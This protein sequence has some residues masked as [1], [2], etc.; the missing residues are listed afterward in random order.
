MEA[1]QSTRVME[2]S[3]DSDQKNLSPLCFRICNLSAVAFYTLQFFYC[4]YIFKHLVTKNERS[5]S[6]IASVIMMIY[7]SISLAIFFGL[8]DSDFYNQEKWSWHQK[9]Y[10]IFFSELPFLFVFMSHWII[11]YQYLELALVL[12]ILGKIAEHAQNAHNKIISIRQCLQATMIIVVAMLVAHFVDKAFYTIQDAT[13][14][15]D[16]TVKYLAVAL[17]LCIMA[18]CCFVFIRLRQVINSE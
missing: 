13:N 15:I 16:N 4:S 6:M 10:F 12:P 18:M 2:G 1:S 3:D 7:S 11:L 9:L 17:K 8:C 5:N 14:I